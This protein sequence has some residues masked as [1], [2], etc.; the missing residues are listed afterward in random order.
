MPAFYRHI[1]M[2]VALLSVTVG[3]AAVELKQLYQNR[4]QVNSQAT[5]ERNQALRDAFTATLLK[6]T[7]DTELINHPAV[8]NALD[9]VRDYVVQYGYQQDD[10]LFLWAQFEQARVE[11]LIQ[12][13]GSGVWSN[14]RPQLLIWLVVEDEN[15]R[16]EVLSSADESILT[17]Q[18]RN[19]AT[20]RGLPVQFP[21]LDLNDRMAIDTVDIWG[22]FE[23]RIAFASARYSPDGVIVARAYQNDPSLAAERWRID[24]TL[25]LGDLRWRGAV[26][27]MDLSLLGADLV[28]DITAQLAQRYRIDASEETSRLWR[29]Q[30]AGLDSLAKAIAAEQLLNDLPAVEDV[31]LIRYQQ[32]Q[33]VFEL[34]TQ[35]APARLMQALDLSKQ[36]KPVYL[37]PESQE[38]PEQTVMPHYLWIQTR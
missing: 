33:G 5:T 16:R 15:L 11:A 36:V 25:N 24:W 14:L 2:L 30:I 9:N 7:G 4:V 23:D 20:A 26:D 29:I 6:V 13:A 27:G 19:A 3:H 22:R 1:L 34:L 18:L 35:A 37:E 31:Q 17:Q 32:H 12:Q 21:V 38:Q 8:Q 10:G 28:A